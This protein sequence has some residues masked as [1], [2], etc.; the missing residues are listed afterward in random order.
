[1]DNLKWDYWIPQVSISNILRLILT[2]ISSFQRA[3]SSTLLG[4]AS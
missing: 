4:V 2:I 3:D 1:M